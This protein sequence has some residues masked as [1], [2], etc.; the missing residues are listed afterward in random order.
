MK[1]ALGHITVAIAGLLSFAV[2]VAI[3]VLVERATGF[4]IFTFSLWLI[5][6]VGALLCGAAAASG[7][8]FASLLFHTRPTWLTLVEVV[9]IAAA[10]MLA[11][12]Y[13]EYAT[14]SLEDGTRIAEF[15]PFT[16]YLQ[17]YLTSME[18]TVGRG[19]TNTGQVGDFGYVLAGLEFLGFIVGGIFVW[20]LLRTQ[21]VCAKC[22]RY[23][24]NLV[25]RTQQF[26]TQDEFAG[27]YDN[28]FKHP[29]D[30]PAFGEALRWSPRAAGQAATT[31]VIQTTS[32]L[33]GCP[34]CG[35]QQVH[36]AVT[37]LNSK[38]EWKDVPAFT[39]AVRIPQGIDLRPAFR[40][41]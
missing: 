17:I 29:V 32:T 19:Q 4:N 34:H 36:Q 11:V 31:G 5:V 27:A 28:L 8:Y 21:P 14:Y 2:T 40:G 18:M 22:G 25:K 38:G 3:V 16:D 24:R 1:S 33:K 10:A 39:R 12:Y 23:V 35:D 15:L 13:A 26:S 41:N 9:V 7:F 20:L 6:P 30:S 37:V